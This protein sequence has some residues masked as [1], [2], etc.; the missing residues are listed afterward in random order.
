MENLRI[1]QESFGELPQASGNHFKWCEAL[2]EKI[3]CRKFALILEKPE[4]DENLPTPPSWDAKL[5]STGKPTESRDIAEKIIRSHPKQDF[6][7]VSRDFV[8]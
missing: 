6:L 2:F 3:R 5:F 4:I 7:K 1:I 8:E